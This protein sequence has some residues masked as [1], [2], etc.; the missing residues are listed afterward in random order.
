MDKEVHQ[1]DGRIEHPQVRYE[2]RDVRFRWILLLIVVLCT[3][4]SGQFLVI[5][6]FFHTQEH[7]QSVR[8]ASEYPLAPKPSTRLPEEP[9]LEQ[10]D[11]LA[12]IEE[13]NVHDREMI[14]QRLLSTYGTTPEKG[15]LRIPIWHAMQQVIAD[16]PVRQQPSAG[17]PPKE[18]GLLYF[19][20]PN[21]GRVFRETP[22]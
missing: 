13:A 14:S 20:D 15:Y 1:P 7:N 22:R 8:K 9:R 18:D 11:R 2:K 6:S 10:L 19:G 21:S 5:R 16:L 4:G 3:L 12:G 17:H